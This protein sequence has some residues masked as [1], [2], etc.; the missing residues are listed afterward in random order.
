MTRLSSD[1]WPAYGLI[2][3]AALVLFA[4]VGPSL[5]GA[6]AGGTN[7]TN[8]T[9][10]TNTTNASV[11]G[12]N[13]TS[14]ANATDNAT[15]GTDNASNRSE[16]VPGVAPGTAG[17]GRGAVDPNGSNASSATEV[18]AGSG[19]AFGTGVGKSVINW[20]LGT[21]LVEG[22]GTLFN[23]ML[24]GVITYLGGTPT[25]QNSGAYGVF[26]VPTGE[27]CQVFFYQFYLP[28][29]IPLSII[30]VL[31][32]SGALGA[33]SALR[34]S[35]PWPT[36]RPK[37]VFAR[38]MLALVL[39]VSWWWIAS[40]TE[41]IINEI[42]LIIMPDA[43]A[44]LSSTTGLL[45]LS[46]A[47]VFTAITAYVAGS[48]QVVLLWLLYGVRDA[49]VIVFR[50]VMPIL[51]TVAI[52]GPHPKV[53]SFFSGIAWQWFTVL[54][55]VLPGA[56]MMRLGFYAGW[57]FSGN[58]LVNLSVSLGFFGVGLFAI[59]LLG[60]LSTTLHSVASRA[61]TGAQPI[62]NRADNAM[63]R[64]AERVKGRVS[65][66]A[67]TRASRAKR[68]L[69]PRDSGP[70]AFQP[71]EPGWAAESPDSSASQSGSK[72]TRASRYGGADD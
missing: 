24:A 33:E 26:G 57:E 56:I 21:K 38:S 67:S 36:P 23:D 20:F 31:F 7:V 40:L 43:E 25:C 59:L 68:R 8:G 70:S 49:A 44:L 53:R 48:G 27:P 72:S 60:W 41:K 39:I 12:G 54:I 63:D 66:S 10:T 61:A 34:I 32:C 50:Y 17:T 9:N 18:S 35:L 3:I 1:Q 65:T 15:N 69:D 13:T 55:V 2:A 64:G 58:T 28:F 51:L 4:A 6:Q 45:Q 62:T 19:G 29:V 52:L 22:F 16:T 71:K 30:L 46:G 42:G 5:A 14:G 37:D 11:A 47:G